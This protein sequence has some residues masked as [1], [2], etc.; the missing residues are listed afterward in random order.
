MKETCTRNT[1]T[2][3][4]WTKT[5]LTELSC[6]MS[7]FEIS[8]KVEIKK[9]KDGKIDRFRWIILDF[10]VCIWFD[11]KKI[12]NIIKHNRYIYIMLKYYN[13]IIN[14]FKKGKNM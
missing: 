10:N 1:S 2:K 8:W 14:N 12:E 13:I 11:D 6:W 5:D 3:I 4:T 9:K 7:L